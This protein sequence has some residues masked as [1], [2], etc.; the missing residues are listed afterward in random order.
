MKFAFSTLMI[1]FVSLSTAWANPAAPRTTKE[2]LVGISDAYIPGGFDSNS[3]AYVVTN[4]IF[5]NGC[6]RFARA[7]VNHDS[8][9]VHSVRVF[10]NV[11]QGMCLMVLVPFTK[12]V[13][14]GRLATGTH[15]IRFHG[16]DG[17][18]LEKTMIVE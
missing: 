14:L 3:E 15:Q 11:Q 17:T 4:G 1:G 16:G 18:Y 9:N 13:Q 5:P 12:E 2:V 8:A 10:A 6:Y 7:D